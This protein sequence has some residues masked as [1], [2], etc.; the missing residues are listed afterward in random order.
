MEQFGVLSLGSRLKRLSDFLYSE[1][2]SVYLAESLMIS[3][4][5]FPILRLLQQQGAL[6]V[7]Q[8]AEGLRLSHPAVSKQVSKMLKESLLVKVP[9]QQ[10][11]RRS[12]IC[13]SEFCC[14]EMVKVEPVL[15]AI[16][17]ELEYYLDAQT[18]SFLTQ[19]SGLESHLLNGPYAMRVILRLHPEKVDI[20]SLSSKTD[21]LVFK[22]LNE[23]WLQRFFP[24]DIYERDQRILN[25]P[26]NEII[27]Q[28]GIVRL[29]FFDG[30]PI[31]S[32]YLMPSGNGFEIG[33]LAV[34]ERFSRLGIGERM[35]KDALN[36]VIEMGGQCVYLESHTSLV[37]ALNLYQKL[38]FT[39]DESCVV[40][41]VPR[42]NLRMTKQL[43][44]EV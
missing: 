15:E 17:K 33:K 18:G 3:S 2:Q 26:Y 24:N 1:V 41:S 20:Q 16:G 44:G 4:T 25:D 19:L 5:Y 6:S 42:A 28:G 21:C 32:Y 13:L 27:E 30:K 35:L 11:Q 43:G 9:D 31:A 37:P 23:A 14:Q 7:M 10:D 40:F 38:G 12:A 22:Q 36:Q 29:A 8:I 39:I 34:G